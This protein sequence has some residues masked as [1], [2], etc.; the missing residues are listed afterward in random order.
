M[1]LTAF[2]V[3]SF[4]QLATGCF[5]LGLI[6][7]IQR[8]HYPLFANIGAKE[9][10]V[11]ERQ[12]VRR[13]SP[14]V[15]PVMVLELLSALAVTLLSPPDSLARSLSWFGLG[16]LA[17]IWGATWLLQVPRHRALESGQDTAVIASLVRTNWLRT[18]AWSLRAPLAAGIL[19]TG[20]EV[21]A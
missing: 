2:T 11:Y 16:L 10:P 1:I 20:L 14:I 4:L 17:M 9:F 7:V 8:V 15:A 6:W 3:W 13:I 12:H 18:L 5:M 19:Y 21:S